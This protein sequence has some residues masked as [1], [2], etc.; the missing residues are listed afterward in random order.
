MQPYET[1]CR[2]AENMRSANSEM[3][4]QCRDVVGHLLECC[5][6]QWWSSRPALPTKI[7]IDDLSE[8][9]KRIKTY[10][11]DRRDRSQAHHEVR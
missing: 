5:R 8:I 9:A 3:I 1:A 2:V 4:V 10:L 11:L 7:D 6:L